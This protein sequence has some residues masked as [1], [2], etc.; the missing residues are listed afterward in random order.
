V[1]RPADEQANEMAEGMNPAQTNQKDVQPLMETHL[2][3]PEVAEKLGLS[4]EAA[5]ALIAAATGAS[6]AESGQQ[7]NPL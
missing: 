5:C 1:R 7:R 3:V 2:T 6:R 4:L